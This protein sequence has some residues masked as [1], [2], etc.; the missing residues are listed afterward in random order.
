MKYILFVLL[1]GSYTIFVN[2]QINYSFCVGDSVILSGSSQN[3]IYDY[4][5]LIIDG[6]NQTDTTSLVS[7]SEIFLYPNSAIFYSITSNF[8]NSLI[9]LVQNTDTNEIGFNDTTVFNIALNE[10]PI[11]FLG[12]DTAIC[13]NELYLFNA[14]VQG[15][16]YWS[17][18]ETSQTILPTS[19]GIYSLTVVDTNGCE[20]FD[21]ISLTVNSSPYIHLGSDSS[22]CED[23]L[24]HLN[25][26]LHNNYSWSTGDTTQLIR[27]TISN[28]Y[29]V[30]VTNEDGCTNSDTIE[31]SIYPLPVFNLAD[32][33]LICHGDTLNLIAGSFSS[34][35]WST[36]A[37]TQN[38]G[39]SIANN[40]SVTVTNSFG[41]NNNHDFELIVKPLP[42]IN[43]GHDIVICEG[44]SHSLNVGSFSVINWSNGLSSQ[45]VNLFEEGE[46]TITVT[47]ANNCSNSDTILL[48]VQ[49]RPIIYVEF[50]LYGNTIQFSAGF[51]TDTI[52]SNDTIKVKNPVSTSLNP[53]ICGELRIFAETE[54]TTSGFPYIAFDSDYDLID[55]NYEEAFTP[56]NNTDSIQSFTIRY[57][58]Y[59]DINDNHNIDND[60]I[61]GD[62]I[63]FKVSVFPKNVVNLQDEFEICSADSLLIHAGDFQYYLWS[64]NE[65]I[66]SI[67][68]SEEDNYYVSVTD[69]NG[70]MSSDSTYLIVHD[71]PFINIGNDTTL[72]AGDTLTIF[73][74]TYAT[75]SWST[76]ETTSQVQ[77]SSSGNYF[78]DVSDVNNCHN[79]DTIIVIVH[80]LPN[81]PL[82]NQSPQTEFCLNDTNFI[83]FNWNISQ[84]Y[85]LNYAINSSFYNEVLNNSTASIS[86]IF[87]QLGNF[88]VGLNFIKDL[89]TGCDAIIDTVFNYHVHNYPTIELGSDT[90]ICENNNIELNAL[91]FGSTYLWSTGDVTEKIIVNQ[92]GLYS[93][94][95]TNQFN[96]SSEDSIEIFISPIPTI[97]LG[98]DTSI[99]DQKYLVL[100]PHSST[101]YDVLWSNNYTTNYINVYDADTYWVKI[102]NEDGCSNIDSIDVSINPLP[103]INL[104]DNYEIC[105]YESQIINIDT[106]FQV[107][108]STGDVTHEIEIEDPGLYYISVIDTNGCTNTKEFYLTVNESPSPVIYGD[109]IVCAN[110]KKIEYF[111]DNTNNKILWNINY[112][113][114]LTS[115]TTESI[116]VNW[117]SI[118]SGVGSLQLRLRNNKGCQASLSKDVNMSE[119]AAPPEA[120]IVLKDNFIL[121][122]KDSSLTGYQWGATDLFGIESILYGEI[123]QFYA[124]DS[125]L[126]FNNFEYWLE[127]YYTSQCKTKTYFDYEKYNHSFPNKSSFIIYPNPSDS[128]CNIEFVDVIN[129]IE[130]KIFNVNMQEVLAPQLKLGNRIININ[131]SGL[132]RG[133]YILKIISESTIDSEFI[134]KL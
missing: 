25:A 83:F 59:Y 2:G 23:Q 64:N 80:D 109:F 95:I 120:E 5:W 19:S 133:V 88:D 121:I 11:V 103:V 117:D 134:Y 114:I 58:V 46:Y 75:Y 14:N 3:Q 21:S 89:N 24:Y 113:Q 104:N 70:C 79:L 93:I 118:P 35:A 42:L 43:L 40:Y 77:I 78:I 52:C 122:C 18:G 63:S 60:D 6:L 96:C 66:E 27:P 107:M 74:G 116:I 26:G 8:H 106:F 17:T 92:A 72:C 76:G 31:L 10:N 34:Y 94:T 47:D 86:V 33:M 101:Y 30:T 61:L 56:V 62:T 81:L 68:L 87:N 124:S 112:G 100:D 115:D 48:E 85:L 69:S 71:L 28:S 7:S 99:C 129:N 108:W 65:T 84:S 105:D 98:S 119:Y 131:L 1:L 90:I 9:L 32:S 36:G 41:C 132:A 82:I 50:S 126:D 57:I 44:M 125:G 110:S 111:T 38:I 37:T 73:S 12:P 16:Y 55:Q 54:G 97:D 102:T 130:I 91:Q 45:V 127:T 22:I 20:G 49:P 123:Y 4:S 13:D 53:A 128:Y 15:S 51:H 29:S 39:L 67:Y